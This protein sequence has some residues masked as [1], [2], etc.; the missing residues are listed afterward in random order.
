LGDRPD[1]ALVGNARHCPAIAWSR[2]TGHGG[3]SRIANIGMGPGGIVA[4]GV[5]YA[6]IALP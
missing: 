6:P 4:C 1:R 3:K 2:A 5:I